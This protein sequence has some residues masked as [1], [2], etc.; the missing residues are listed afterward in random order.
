MPT[1]LPDDYA[2]VAPAQFP[3]IAFNEIPPSPNAG[4]T[5][6]S[7]PAPAP[8]PAPSPAPLPVSSYATPAAQ[9]PAGQIFPTVG[10]PGAR[11]GVGEAHWGTSPWGQSP[12]QIPRDAQWNW[13]RELLEQLR[14]KAGGLN[15]V[16]LSAPSTFVGA[17]STQPTTTTPSS[18]LGGYG[19]GRRY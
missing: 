7:P 3:R 6:P 11:V 5:A 4:G 9:T 13:L 18:P 17:P 10:V 15:P 16:D 2:Y 14:N 12:G 8:T 19:F 1:Q